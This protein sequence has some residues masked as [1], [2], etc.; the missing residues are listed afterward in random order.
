MSDG[1]SNSFGPA[2]SFARWRYAAKPASWPKLLVPAALGQVLGICATGEISG[3]GLVLGLA[4]TLADLLFIVFLNDWG[5]QR[6]DSLKREMFPDGCSPKTLPD[7]ILTPRA[8]LW[9]G[10]GFGLCAAAVGLGAEL[11]LGRRFALLGSLASLAVFVAY[12]LPPIRLNYRGGGELLETL[13]VGVLLPWFSFYLQSGEVWGPQ[14]WVLPGF[15]L[16]SFSSAVASG[17]ADEES[18]RRGGKVT[19]CSAFGNAKA[20]RLIE[21]LVLGGALAW[22]VASSAGTVPGPRLG[23]FLAVAVV[24]TQWRRIRAV[25][26]TAITAAF[27]AQRRYKQSLHRAIWWS[28]LVLCAGMMLEAT[29]LW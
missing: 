14:L 5:D 28:T 29:G 21:W 9:A 7:G 2:G 23:V 1:A 10:L 26:P 12:T 4:F 11:W 17:L 3:A 25:S 6:V 27:D 8:L 16:L 19:I 20:R 24:L 13:G 22:S 18:D 15:A